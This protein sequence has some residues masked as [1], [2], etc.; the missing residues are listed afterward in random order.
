MNELNNQFYRFYPTIDTEPH[1]SVLSSEVNFL[2]QKKTFKK[3]LESLGA[4]GRT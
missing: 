2:I 4:G 1:Y 3:N